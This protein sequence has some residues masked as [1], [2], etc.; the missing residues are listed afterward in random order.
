MGKIMRILGSTIFR[1]IMVALALLAIVMF[2]TPDTESIASKE[3]FEELAE[4]LGGIQDMLVKA[5]TPEWM[6]KVYTVFV[7]K[8]KW[9][10]VRIYSMTDTLLVL[11]FTRDNGFLV[12]SLVSKPSIVF[13]ET[14]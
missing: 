3:T 9:A 8:T 4:D 1:L 12:I 5:N 2:V 11:Q 14:K 13:I 10:N 7:N 6:G